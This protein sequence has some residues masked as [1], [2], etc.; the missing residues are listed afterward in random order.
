MRTRRLTLCPPRVPS[1]LEPQPTTHN[2][3]TPP[4]HPPVDFANPFRSEG[5][6][7][8][9]YV[10]HPER[11]V[12]MLSGDLGSSLLGWA[13]FPTANNADSA[14]W[15]VVLNYRTFPGVTTSYNGATATWTS[16]LFWDHF[17]RV[18]RSM[19]HTGTGHVHGTYSS[20]T[21]ASYEQP[22]GRCLFPFLPPPPWMLIGACNPML[23]PV[24]ESA[25][26]GARGR[27]P[28]RAVPHVPGRLHGP[29]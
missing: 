15:S 16:T 27:P 5:R 3:P 19:Y 12:Y 21:G 26:G 24:H 28:L 6:I 2:T 29:E 20:S 8:Q 11:Y 4:D 10:L 18:S 23:C 9:Q 1:L 22:A 14:T 17:S 7:K 25:S 13:V